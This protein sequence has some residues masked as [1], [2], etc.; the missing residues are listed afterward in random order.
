MTCAG[1]LQ[2]FSGNASRKLTESICEYLG[3]TPGKAIV[4]R[5]SDGE[6]QV[7]ICEHVRG[8]DVFLVNSTCPP[9]NDHLMELLIM[10]DAVRRASADRI[11]A[12]IPYFGYARQDRKDK[13]RVPITAKL[14]ANLITAAGANRV[15]TVDLHCGQ[16]QGF[17][18]IPLDHLRGDVV[19]VEE[20]SKQHFN[21]DFVVVS[22]DMGSVARA[23]EFASRLGLPL[24]IVDK[25]RPKEN[26]SE[27]M[28]IIGDVEG[29]HAILFDDMVDTA[30][31]LVKAAYALKAHGALSVRACATHPVLSGKAIKSIQESPI[32]EIFVCNSI[33]LKPEAIDT[34]KFKVLTLAPLIAKAI[35]NIHNEQSVSSLLTQ[36]L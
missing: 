23:R 5:F 34:G 22:P 3:T 28:N 31:T 6:V 16:I 9:V 15:L 20:F 27:V 33:E 12:V 25:R 21:N 17:F 11:T 32:E 4:D 13:G 2:I 29:Y 26:Q 7:Q 19:F 1:D 18:D 30:G 8:R 14:V 36:H 24:A 35:K 10:I